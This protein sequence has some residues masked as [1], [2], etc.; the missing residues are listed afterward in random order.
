MSP[1]N[2]ERKECRFLVVL[3]TT[4]STSGLVAH[5]VLFIRSMNPSA[6][7]QAAGAPIEMGRRLILKGIR[8]VTA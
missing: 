2:I 3:A 1:E 8:R 6:R 5:A 7:D 4:I